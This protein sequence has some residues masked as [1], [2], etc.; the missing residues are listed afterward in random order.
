MV[1]REPDF[2]DAGFRWVHSRHGCR[3]V[4]EEQGRLEFQ[5]AFMNRDG[6]PDKFCRWQG[7]VFESTAENGEIELG[8]AVDAIEEAEKVDTDVWSTEGRLEFVHIPLSLGIVIPTALIIAESV[9][10]KSDHFLVATRQQADVKEHLGKETCG[11]CAAGEAKYVYQVSF[12]I[13]P[14]DEAIASQNVV[15]KRS[16]DRLIEPRRF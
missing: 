11:V 5:T 16:P 15:Y 8:H 14:H 6:M 12:F 9:P 2:L 7:Y 13:V 1:S 4:H 10:C 3:I